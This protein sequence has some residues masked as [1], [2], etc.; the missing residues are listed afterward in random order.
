MP[1]DRSCLLR[2]ETVES[3]FILWRLTK[4]PKYRE[5]GWEVVQALERN[6]KVEGGCSGIKNVN[7]RRS[8]QHFVKNQGPDDS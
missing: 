5:W 3:Y 4:D 8:I 6:C 2:P 1:R 7:V